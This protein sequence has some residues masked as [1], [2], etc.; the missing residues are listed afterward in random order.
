[1][2]G[3]EPEYERTAGV[4]RAGWGPSQDDF[5]RPETQGETI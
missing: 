5:A 3:P 1:M 2:R 4:A